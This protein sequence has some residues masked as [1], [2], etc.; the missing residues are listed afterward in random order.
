MAR[1]QC[2]IDGCSGK[3]TT[4]GLCGA[5]YSRLLKYGDPQADKPVAT[6]VTP[7]EKERLLPIITRLRKKGWS[8]QAIADEVGGRSAAW[9]GKVIINAGVE[10][11]HKPSEIP[12]GRPSAWAWHKC[13]CD[14]CLQ[15]RTEYKRLEREKRIAK[16]VTA[17]HGTATAYTQGCR[18]EACVEAARVRLAQRQERSRIPAGR[19][20]RRWEQWEAEIAFDTDYTIEERAKRVGRTYAAVDNFIRAQMR[21]PDDPYGVKKHLG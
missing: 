6:H 4:R 8:Y 21:R 5:H 11:G 3:V 13:R 2:K 14:V 16:P 12:H 17:E 1:K 15:A 18:C 20:G 19:H 10:K 7:E 9:V